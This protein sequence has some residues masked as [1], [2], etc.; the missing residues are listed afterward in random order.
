[1]VIFYYTYTDNKGDIKSKVLNT[2]FEQLDMLEAQYDDCAIYYED[3]TYFYSVSY[4]NFTVYISFASY[5]H[6]IDFENKM[7]KKKNETK[8][9]SDSDKE[10]LENLNK[11]SVLVWCIKEAIIKF[12]DLKL[13]DLLSNNIDIDYIEYR[14]RYAIIETKDTLLYLNYGIRDSITFT[15]VNKNEIIEDIEFI[16]LKE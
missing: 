16:E 3:K 10:F 14:N 9:I 1:M 4:A 12:F 7:H 5:F 13:Y 6:A 2:I 11:S 15:I 8:F